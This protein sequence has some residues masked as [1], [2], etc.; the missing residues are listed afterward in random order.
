MQCI[1]DM[2]WYDIIKYKLGCHTGDFHD[3]WN[4][5]I[6]RKYVEKIQFLLKPDKNN[7]TLHEEQYTF[8]PYLSEFFLEWETFQVKLTENIKAYILRSKL[9]KNLLVYEIIWKNSVQPDRPQMAIWRMRY[10]CWIPK[11]TN[12][13]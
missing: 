12:T 8:W 10:L 5:S 11:A 13:H 2:I 1:Y 9:F 7:G 4:L 6:F 3:I